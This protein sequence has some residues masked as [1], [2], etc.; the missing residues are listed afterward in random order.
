[1]TAGPPTAF[2]RS[3]WVIPGKLMAD[4]YP[5]AKTAA[6]A[7]EK[8]NGMV[9]AGI[10]HTVSLME[11][12]ETGRH[13]EPFVPY[14]APFRS[15]GINCVRMPIRDMNI[16]SVDEMRAILDGIDSGIA[17]GTPTYVHCWGGKGRTGTVVGC[18]LIRHGLAQPASAVDRITELQAMTNGTLS[19]SPENERQRRFVA[20]WMPGQ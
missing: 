1:M 14:E 7:Q 11:E 2:Q 16:P 5:G 17:A 3:Y 9:A 15:R 6:E 13:G 10:R 12:G 4:C 20:E 19:P 8:L 18:Y